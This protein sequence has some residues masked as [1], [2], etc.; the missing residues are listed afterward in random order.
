VENNDLRCVLWDGR[1]NEYPAT[2]RLEDF[3][4]IAASGKL[5]ARK[6][7]PQSSAPL[8]DRIDKELLK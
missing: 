7:D 5:F 3:Q 1:R 8:M 6:M 4:E 2:M